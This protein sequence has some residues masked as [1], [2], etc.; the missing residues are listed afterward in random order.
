MREW[1]GFAVVDTTRAGNPNLIAQR[2][3]L[4]AHVLGAVPNEMW[5]VPWSESPLEDLLDKWDPP[6]PARLRK[7]VLH[8]RH[9]PRL[10]EF[11]KRYGVS[12]APMF[13]GY[14]G[15]AKSVL[16]IPQRGPYDL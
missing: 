1:R 2:G 14:A 5:D 6:S 10:L 7:F 9:V 4:T 16:E 13:P 8:R 3:Y 15:I 11:L 12:T